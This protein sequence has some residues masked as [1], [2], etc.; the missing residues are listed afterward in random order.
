MAEANIALPAD[1]RERLSKLELHAR[2]IVEGIVSGLHKSPYQGYSIEFAQ[3]REYT[4]GDELKHL[5]WKVY[6]R[7]DRFYIKQYEEETNLTATMLLDCSASMLYRS[8]DHPN[9]SMTKYEYGALAASALAFLLL[10]QQDTAGLILFDNE[11]RAQIAPSSHPTTLRNFARSMATIE[12]SQESEVKSLF[13]RCAEEIRRRGIVFL[14]SDFFFAREHLQ[15]G[16]QHLRHKGQEVVLFHVMDPDELLFPF[17]DNLKFEAF[18][19]PDEMFVEPRSLRDAYLQA[20][21]E[22]RRDMEK[23]CSDLR[24]DYV[25]LET[26]KPLKSVLAEYL[27]TYRRRR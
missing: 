2:T 6:G 14:I 25:L 3:H 19:T 4:W 16:L 12:L 18:E 13:H 1:V 10:R 20:V 21:L 8:E 17:N 7:S 24:I 23:T 11:I 22:F 9:V 27:S 26:S 15:A 5:D